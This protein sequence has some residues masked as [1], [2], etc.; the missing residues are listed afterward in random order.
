MEVKAA[1]NVKKDL[2]ESGPQ[3]YQPHQSLP[4]IRILSIKNPFLRA[5]PEKLG[6][7]PALHLSQLQDEYALQLS[8]TCSYK[9][10]VSFREYSKAFRTF[11]IA[12]WE[13]WIPELNLF[14][15]FFPIR[16]HRSFLASESTSR[17][18]LFLFSDIRSDLI[19]SLLVCLP[20]YSKASHSHP[21]LLTSVWLRISS[22]CS[23]P[24]LYLHT[25]HHHRFSLFY[26]K[27]LLVFLNISR[28]EG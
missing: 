6:I 8:Q 4:Y 1:C 28:L 14:F 7:Q 26:W 11:H 13:I 24:F 27:Q 19:V 5:D 16:N 18:K 3:C 22:S 17:D 10:W 12:G 20:K 25:I 21:S 15:F 9:K 2:S 23:L